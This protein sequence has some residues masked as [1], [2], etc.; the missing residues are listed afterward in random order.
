MAVLTNLN[1]ANATENELPMDIVEH[2]LRKQKWKFSRV[3]DNEMVAEIRGRWCDYSL[4]FVWSGV[5][6]AFH[7]TCA[8]DVRVPQNFQ[9]D[10][11]W[12]FSE[13]RRYFYL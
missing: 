7:F 3:C 11:L 8:F 12:F 4:H 10:S 6:N 2:V 13:L 5:A 1:I 9:I